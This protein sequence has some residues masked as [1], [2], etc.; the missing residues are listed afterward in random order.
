MPISTAYRALTDCAT[1]VREVYG[2][3]AAALIELWRDQNFLERTDRKHQWRYLSRFEDGIWLHRQCLRCETVDRF[4]PMG[5]GEKKVAH[6][7]LADGSVVQKSPNPMPPCR[8][9]LSARNPN[10][11]N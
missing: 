1:H 8:P 3:D 6:Y 2:S 9:A 4:G 7:L 11:E 5:P 10:K